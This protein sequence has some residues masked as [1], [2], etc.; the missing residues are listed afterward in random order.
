MFLLGMEYI[1]EG[2]ELPNVC[3]ITNP[4]HSITYLA[5]TQL[6]PVLLTNRFM[7]VISKKC[8]VWKIYHAECG[9]FPVTNLLKKNGSGRVMG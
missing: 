8:E 6:F 9:P 3:F 4:K 5:L 2:A 7:E 1:Y